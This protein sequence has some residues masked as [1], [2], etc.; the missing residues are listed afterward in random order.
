MADVNP[1][2]RA[3]I[4]AVDKAT[5][6]LDRIGSKIKSIGR[7]AENAGNPWGPAAER[8]SLFTRAANMARAATDRVVH[9]GHQFHR[10]H[11]PIHQTTH[12]LGEMHEK[13]KGIGKKLSE[14]LPMFGALGAGASIAG[15][16][17]LTHK[18]A[19]TSGEFVRTR[20]KLGM[21]SRELMAFNYAAKMTETPLDTM[22]AGMGKFAKALGLAAAGKNKDVAALFAHLHI[23]LRDASGHILTAAEAFPKIAEAIQHTTDVTMRQRME[24]ALFGRAGLEMNSMLQASKED[25]GKWTDTA[26]KLVYPFTAEDREHLEEFQHSWIN[27]EY[28]TQGV[29][30]ELGAK[31]APILT[32]VL[33]KF[34]EWVSA[35]RDWIATGIADKVEKLASW[36]MK[37]D[38]DKVVGQT[39][40]WVQPIT[41]VVTQFGGFKTLIFGSAAAMAGPWVL[42]GA[43]M[44]KLLAEIAL[45]AAKT[46]WAIGVSLV[47]AL[48]AL[49]IKLGTVNAL[50]MRSPVM[51]AA[52]IALQAYDIAKNG[53]DANQSDID[54]LSDKERQDAGITRNAGGK[55][56]YKNGEA[57]PDGMEQNF[58][59]WLKRQ[60][61]DSLTHGW[62][63]GPR[64]E[65]APSPYG[66]AD[67]TGMMLPSASQ[68]VLDRLQGA[69][70]SGQRDGKVDV[71]VTFENLPQGA[72][73]TVK[74]SGVTAEPTVDVGHA[75]PGV[76]P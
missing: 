25:M 12:A 76:A 3:V 68:D 51:R 45:G 14:I 54:R 56:Q 49:E 73:A 46:A 66:F 61:P 63:G 71:N 50:V 13:L 53:R 74:G 58:D 17:E 47:N 38:F 57:V 7:E 72:A 22:Q 34:T 24:L 75:F 59:A 52:M 41:D 37:L 42:A 64:T 28:A 15:L 5:A 67:P 33:E 36:V 65:F 20:D 8:V 39:K 35:N 62:G 32:P 70:N 1:V 60:I 18:V 10:V 44:V 27:L 11:E 48:G 69:L 21:T 2:F 40:E 29:V 55:W 31:L 43:M 6:V 16:F 26:S 19:E 23:P 4:T 9:A 30:N